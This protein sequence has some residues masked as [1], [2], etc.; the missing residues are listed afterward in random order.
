MF[1]FV[2]ITWSENL[3][4]VDRMWREYTQQ[5]VANSGL[6]NENFH[7]Y[8]IGNS[9]RKRP[10]IIRCLLLQLF[11]HKQKSKLMTAVHLVFFWIGWQ[12][13]SLSVA[14]ESYTKFE[15]KYQLCDMQ[16]FFSTICW[17][18]VRVRTFS[19]TRHDAHLKGCTQRR[20]ERLYV[21]GFWTELE[22]TLQPLISCLGTPACAQSWRDWL[23]EANPAAV[24][25]VRIL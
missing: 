18:C 14:V 8:R 25:N 7:S 2:G 21:E 4:F 24:I 23:R 5:L 16:F 10:C 13:K 6:C 19:D 3:R 15:L 17:K 12:R 11:F 20:P 9:V 22:V 1:K